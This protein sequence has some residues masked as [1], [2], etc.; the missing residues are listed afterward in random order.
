MTTHEHDVTTDDTVAAHEGFDEPDHIS[1][2]QDDADVLF[3]PE[4]EMRFT[5]RWTDIQSRFVD[6]PHEAVASADDLVAEVMEVIGRRFAERR[7]A[8]GRQW[9][10]DG[11][12]ETEDLRLAMQRYRAFFHRLLSA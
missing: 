8:L 10:V 6:D 12:P 5:R 11:E 4:D 1:V 3:T 2:Q 9:A 7:S